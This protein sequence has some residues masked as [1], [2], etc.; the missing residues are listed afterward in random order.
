MSLMTPTAEFSDEIRRCREEFMQTGDSMD[1]TGA[2]FRLEH[3]RS[4]L[5][6]P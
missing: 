2:L 6:I 1:G 5:T 3:L 4:G